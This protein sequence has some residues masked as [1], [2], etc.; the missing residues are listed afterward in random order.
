MP[1]TFGQECTSMQLKNC[2]SVTHARGM[3][4][5]HLG[6]RTTWYQSPQHGH[7]KN[8]PLISW[9]LFPTAPGNVK[10]LVVD[11][12][13]FTKWVEAKTLATIDG[14]NIKKFIWEFIICRFGLPMEI[15]S[16]N[17]TQF[18][19]Q[20]LQEWL[21]SMKI[22]Q[23]FTSVAHPQGNG[24]VERANRSI[25]EGI[26][27]RLGT[28]RSGWVDELPHVLWAHRT[29]PKTSNG[30]TP[31]SLTYGTEAVIPTEVTNPSPRVLLAESIDNDKELRMNLDFLDERRDSAHVR[32]AAYKR[33]LEKYYNARVKEQTFRVGDFV[34][35]NNEASNAEKPGKLAPTRSEE[36]TS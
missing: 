16:D 27:T 7:F 6:Q 13:Y 5:E 35:R 9:D 29:L 36:H 14:C 8:G 32:E 21:H 1:D 19:D 2:G 23:I 33:Q 20:H 17:G 4:L 18:A 10:Y 28:K 22:K 11:I 15:V 26:K 31:F 25:V 30:E 12:D 3:H 24:Q 34:F